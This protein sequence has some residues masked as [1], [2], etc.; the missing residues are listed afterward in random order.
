MTPKDE[1]VD[2]TGT[3]SAYTC[4]ECSGTLWEVQDDGLLRFACRVGHT[5]SADSMM[6]DQSEAAERALWAAL[7]ALQ[8]RADLSARMA[9]RAQERGHDLAAQRYVEMAESA[10]HDSVVLRNLLTN[11]KAIQVK[12]RHDTVQHQQ[13]A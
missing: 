6:E 3:P 5:L 7:R 12:E 8:E 4:P 1:T 10:A 9:Q 2:P 13:S 11:G